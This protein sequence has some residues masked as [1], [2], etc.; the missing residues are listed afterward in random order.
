[1]QLPWLHYC[2][3]C[4]NP[5][6]SWKISEPCAQ[7]RRQHLLTFPKCSHFHR[8]C[9][10]H[11]KCQRCHYGAGLQAAPDSPHVKFCA[12]WMSGMWDLEQ[13]VQQA[14]VKYRSRKKGKKSSSSSIGVPVGP[15]IGSR[16]DD[17]VHDPSPA[18]SQTSRL[19]RL[20]PST[21]D[22]SSVDRAWLEQVV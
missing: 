3:F 7:L 9:D 5:E 8:L 1:M 2:W 14:V 15:D 18:R 6:S 20:E 17:G 10:N 11:L 13:T 21:R 19:S 22:C 16:C 4:G 12:D